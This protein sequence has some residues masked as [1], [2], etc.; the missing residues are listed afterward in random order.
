MHT[1][2]TDIISGWYHFTNNSGQAFGG[3]GAQ[4][5]RTL[6]ILRQWLAEKP[7]EFGGAQ[8]NYWTHD[9]RVIV[10]EENPLVFNSRELFEKKLAETINP[11]V[12]SFSDAPELWP[13]DSGL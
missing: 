9:G 1:T 12:S 11:P 6:E 13:A 5:A 8:V 7:H 2:Q 3:M 4:Y 10:E